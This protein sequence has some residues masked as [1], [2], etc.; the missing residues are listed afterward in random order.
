MK[1]KGVELRSQLA[2][3]I[4]SINNMSCKQFTIDFLERMH[5]ECEE[6]TFD[7]AEDII[8]DAWHY[9]AIT[10]LEVLKKNTKDYSVISNLGCKISE[11]LRLIQNG[12]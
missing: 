9:E 5:E 7:I 2:D 8:F 6:S 10:Y 1:M 3:Y 4:L 12:K 11:L